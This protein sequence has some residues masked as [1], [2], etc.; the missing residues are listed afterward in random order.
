MVQQGRVATL[1]TWRRTPPWCSSYRQLCKM[2]PTFLRR[3]GQ[4][5][6]KKSSITS[7]SQFPKPF[8]GS[9]FETFWQLSEDFKE[10]RSI[11]L[12]SRSAC[13]VGSLAAN[14]RLIHCCAFLRSQY[15][16]QQ[17]RSNLAIFVRSL[18]ASQTP[19]SNLTTDKTWWSRIRCYL[20]NY[21]M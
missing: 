3:F 1:L 7:T 11:P 9:E 12:A 6:K 21:E 20:I 17:K 14:I 18:A 10:S 19:H 5:L 8:L 4:G 15:L 16:E 13:V 2:H